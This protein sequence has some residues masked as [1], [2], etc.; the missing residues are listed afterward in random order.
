MLAIHIPTSELLRLFSALASYV[1]TGGVRILFPL[2][3][4]SYGQ[5]EKKAHRRSAG[6]KQQP[7]A[8]YTV[9]DG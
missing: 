8:V 9:G 3:G 1:R 6:N 4:F 5:E 2:A 7:S